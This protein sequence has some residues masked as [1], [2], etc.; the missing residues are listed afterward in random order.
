MNSIVRNNSYVEFIYLLAIVIPY[1]NNYELTF[2]TWILILGLTFK[3]KYALNIIRFTIPFVIILF[4]AFLSSFFYEYKTFG[5]IKDIT[6]LL[7]PIIGLLIGYQLFNKK[8]GFKL[9][10]KTGVLISCVHLI[11]ILSIV[12]KYHSMSVNLLREYGGYFSDYE[13]YTLIILLFSS[14]FELEYSKINKI[15]LVS[16]VSLSCFLY[17]SRTNFLQFFIFLMAMYGLFKITKR[18]TKWIVLITSFLI[19][20]YTTIYN[21]N[22]KRSGKGIEAFL[23]KVK[24]APIEPFK[25]KINKNDWKD[26]NDNYRSFENISVMKNNSHEGL[27][28]I[29]FGQGLGSEINLGRR[30]LSND[31]TYVRTIPIVHNG[32]MTVFLKSGLIGVFFCIYSIILFFRN[33]EPKNNF[34]KQINFLFIGTGVFLFIS[35]WVFLGLYF[36]YDVKS[37]LI[38]FLIAMRQF[39]IQK[40]DTEN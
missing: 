35:Y 14:R 11:I 6:Y 9:I 1:F 18:S 5:F 36:K 27:S 12:L 25:T 34:I 15:I 23:Y 40:Y 8:N 30:V 39:Y 33:P 38:G 37:I 31:G 24:I 10:I 7:K 17:L 4:L 3:E 22:P 29:I 32:F 2:I 19:L 13:I 26:F 16:I 20:G 28:A 21:M